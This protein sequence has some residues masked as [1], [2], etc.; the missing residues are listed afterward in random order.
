[1][2]RDDGYT[3]RGIELK[4]TLAWVRNPSVMV[5]CPPEW[6]G[7]SGV[8]N[9]PFLSSAENDFAPDFEDHMKRKYLRSSH[10]PRSVNPDERNYYDHVHALYMV[11][12]RSGGPDSILRRI[13]EEVVQYRD[14]EI[15]HS[16]PFRGHYLAGHIRR[17]SIPMELSVVRR[18]YVQGL[19][20]DY[21][22]SG[23]RRSF[24][25]AREM[26]DA[27]LADSSRLPESYTWTE[28]TPAWTIMGLTSFYEATLERK[29][30]EAAKRVA[31]V[32]IEHQLRMAALYPNQG[33]VKG[34]TGGFL[35]N[36]LGAWFDPDEST[37]SG[38]GSPFMT[39]LLLEGM[40]KLYWLTGDE[41][42]RGQGS[43]SRVQGGG[44]EL[45]RSIL[46]ACDW[47]ADVAYEPKKSAFWYIARD[48]AN[49]ELTPGLAPLFLQSL[50][51]AYQATGEER[52]REIARAILKD[53]DWGGHTKEF[54]QAMRTSGQG[55]LLLSKPPRTVSLTQPRTAQKVAR[56]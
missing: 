36:R 25:V 41:G 27:L 15:V 47:L 49:I 19:L 44:E 9:L 24:D 43:G 40:I 55:L 34:Q 21:Y 12:V 29:Y 30:L 54:N 22:F 32:M 3:G 20:E 23:D 10:P 1:M 14:Y 37:A 46:A 35:Q 45:R 18:L 56:P 11:L 8:Y 50:G 31:G 42:N 33:G 2:R 16:G 7:A 39:A 38:A 5:L 17:A 6:Y 13:R 48:P 52:F 28:R 26:A 4:P 53:Q 51:F